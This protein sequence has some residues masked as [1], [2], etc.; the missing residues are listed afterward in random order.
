MVPMRIVMGFERRGEAYDR[1]GFG[2]RVKSMLVLKCSGSNGSTEESVEA[3]E[4]S[5]RRDELTP[6]TEKTMR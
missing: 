2:V 5:M 6:T 1:R 3:F 4:M